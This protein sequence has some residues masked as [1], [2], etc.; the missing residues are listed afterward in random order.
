MA[1]TDKEEG[2]WS[3]DEVYN[4]QN[5]GDIWPDQKHLYAWG[6]NSYGLFANSDFPVGTGTKRSSPTQVMGNEFTKIFSS[7]AMSILFAIRADGTLWGW[8]QNG[9]PGRLGV[10]LPYGSGRS[11][12]TQIAGGGTTWL[13]A[14]A[15]LFG[16]LGN[17]SD[18]T[19]WAW[20]YNNEGQLGDNAGTQSYEP[21]QIPGAWSTSEYG[22]ATSGEARFAI[23]AD[24]TLWA[25]GKNNFGGLGINDRTSRSSPTQIPGTTWASVDMSYSS[26]EGSA[27]AVKTDGTAWVW[28]WNDG[29]ALGLNQT[30]SSPTQKYSS[31]VQLPGTTWTRIQSNGSDGVVGLKTNGTIW[32]WGSNGGGQLGHNNR[33]Q[34]SSPVQ[35]GSATTWNDIQ[36]SSN[37]TMASKTDGTL[38]AWGNAT[39][40]LIPPEGGP[41]AAR[42]S[43][44]QIPGTWDDWAFASSTIAFGIKD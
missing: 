39:Y 8:G 17:K 32:A 27:A 18:G 38:Y 5:Q 22:M 11:S 24:G 25:W 29:G 35:V 10:G 26:N 40:G 21:K 37:I 33:T 19:L 41:G 16:S 14:Q 2:V 36:I 7:N 43:P 44:V 42:S 31:P 9:F 4:K 12:P 34:Y 3:L 30:A 6:S 28:G 20:G 23:K 1:I 15:G 13:K